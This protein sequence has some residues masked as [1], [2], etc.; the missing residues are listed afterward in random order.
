MRDFFSR[1]FGAENVLWV[2]GEGSEP[3]AS[4]LQ[5]LCDERRLRLESE[6]YTRRAMEID[7][8]DRM[9]ARLRAGLPTGLTEAEN[10]LLPELLE[11]IRST[12]R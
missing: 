7:V 3:D 2:K 8:V 4:T 11:R 10:S 12:R 6:A 1:H 5:A 9:L